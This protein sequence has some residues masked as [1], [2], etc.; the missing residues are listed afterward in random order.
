MFNNWTQIISDNVH[1]IYS[2]DPFVPY[3]SSPLGRLWSPKCCYSPVICLG[4][5]SLSCLAAKYLR[6]QTDQVY[7]ESPV[8][9]CMSAVGMDSVTSEACGLFSDCH[10]LYQDRQL[11]S[12]DSFTLTSDLPSRANQIK[13]TLR[14]GAHPFQNQFHSRN[15]LKKKKGTLKQ[16][17]ETLFLKL[18]K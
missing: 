9:S 18:T 2:I 11:S 14:L 15:E 16:Q 4:I 12:G 10:S 7:L 8:L 3:I 13:N 6:V 17:L 5:L 1:T